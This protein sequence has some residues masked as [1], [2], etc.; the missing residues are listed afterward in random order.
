MKNSPFNRVTLCSLVA[1]CVI[2]GAA[3]SVYGQSVN[4][5]STDFR[6]PCTAGEYMIGGGNTCPKNC[7]GLSDFPGFDPNDL[8]S[9]SIQQGRVPACKTYAATEFICYEL[10]RLK[11]LPSNSAFDKGCSASDLSF[12]YNLAWKNVDPKR[13][14]VPIGQWAADE[15]NHGEGANVPTAGLVVAAR[16]FG[17][18]PENSFPSQWPD[19]KKDMFDVYSAF[20]KHLRER[21]SLGSAF[22]LSKDCPECRMIAP[23]LTNS[24]W[25][26]IDQ[27]VDNIV[28]LDT[29]DFDVLEEINRLACP[30]EDRVLPPADW[31]ADGFPIQ[32]YDPSYDVFK[33][34]P[35]RT[36]TTKT[37]FQTLWQHMSKPKAIAIA[38]VDVHDWW[39]DRFP[40]N[41]K[42]E[43]VVV[44]MKTIKLDADGKI[45]CYFMIKNSWGSGTQHCQERK[46][47]ILCWPET[48]IV[49]VSVELLN[50]K[51]FNA[52]TW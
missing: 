3:F 12:Q 11:V 40:K 26:H 19:E 36:V 10:K 23:G 30:R 16:K 22:T 6:Q 14:R 50:G 20:A 8:G 47:D 34:D 4:N 1:S 27:V 28:N 18:C 48:G 46:P 33:D 24:Q 2:A 31:L 38:G 15:S 17:V 7:V 45:H 42:H 29:D 43:V 44:G 52:Y 21:K 39:P 35:T 51:N 32:R 49:L 41:S 13:R 25:L 5:L 9:F 37:N